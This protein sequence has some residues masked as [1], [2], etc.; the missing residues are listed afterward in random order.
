M[1][2]TRIDPIAQ[3]QDDFESAHCGRVA[4][5][6]AHARCMDEG[7]NLVAEQIWPRLLEARASEEILAARYRAAL[8]QALE[9]FEL[10]LDESIEPIDQEAA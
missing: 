3:L 10:A 5:E 8:W 6:R 2:P 4:L 7:A 9:D 1:K